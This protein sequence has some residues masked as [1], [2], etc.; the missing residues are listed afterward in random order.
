MQFQCNL[1]LLLGRIEA[2]RVEFT[3]VELTYDAELVVPVEKVA[4]GWPLRAV[5]G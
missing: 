1:S 5:R 2:R 4:E 3:G